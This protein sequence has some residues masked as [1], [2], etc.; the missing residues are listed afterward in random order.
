MDKILIDKILIDLLKKSER[1]REFTFLEGDPVLFR[2]LFKDKDIPVV[3]V[4]DT[5]LIEEIGEILGFVGQFKWEDSR[6]S[7]LDGDSYSENMK[8]IGYKWFE[9]E[10]MQCL[11]ILVPESEW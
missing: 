1:N 11:D 6:I 7:S 4:H 10:G 8:V 5:S 3:Q 2:D 9:Y